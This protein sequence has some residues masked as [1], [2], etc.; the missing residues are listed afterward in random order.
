M[1][2]RPVILSELLMLVRILRVFTEDN[3]SPLLVVSVEVIAVGE[4]SSLKGD[5]LSLV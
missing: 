5:M 1:D 2:W 4:T 3:L